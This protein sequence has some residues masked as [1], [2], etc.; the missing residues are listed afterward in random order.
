MA[1]TTDFTLAISSSKLDFVSDNL[2]GFV[3]SR[4][5]EFALVDGDTSPFAYK[6]YTNIQ[7]HSLHKGQR[8][9]QEELISLPGCDIFGRKRFHFTQ[10]T[11]L[12]VRVAV[13][14]PLTEELVESLSL[15]IEYKKKYTSAT[16]LVVGS[17][18]AT[19]DE[20][21]SEIDL[22][23]TAETE[24]DNLRR[25]DMGILQLVCNAGR[26]EREQADESVKELAALFNRK[27]A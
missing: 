3:R 24:L 4:Q 11:V 5:R 6:I 23:V 16:D 15:S 13:K 18:L 2:F 26:R 19:W 10:V 8:Y 27:R 7:Q 20:C 17:M 25:D 12:N 14:N 21:S 1:H 22:T 9:T